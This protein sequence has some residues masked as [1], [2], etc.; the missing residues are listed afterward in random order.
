MVQHIKTIV[1]KVH[2][3]RPESEKI[4]IAAQVIRDGGLVAF[5][6]ETVYGLGANAL[7]ERAVLKIFESKKR[8]ADNPLIVHI[9]NINDVYLLAERLPKGAEV[10]INKFWPG[11]LTLIVPRSELVPDAT[12]AGL[13]TVA[14]RMPSHP[15]ARALIAE[16]NVPIAAPSA[17]IAGMP[18]PTTVT[19]VLADLNGRIEAVIDGGEITYGV[20][21]TVL[22]ITTDPPTIL[23]PGPA[24]V[25]EL[26]DLI[27]EVRVHPVARAEV[28]AEVVIA[29]S[30]G[31]KYKH[32]APAAEIVVV[33]GNLEKIQV[34]VQELANAQR[35]S[36]KKVG[37]VA[38]EETAASYHAD[39]VKIVGSRRDPRTVSKNLF[40][41]L[42]ELDSEGV[43]SA[44][45]EGIEPLGIGLAVMN[46]LR[47]AAGHNIVRVN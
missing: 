22:D 15:V 43:S 40:R 25:E 9:S 46:R 1:L 3:E 36:G 42:R 24:T 47:K 2:P 8:P 20:E 23:R 11:P 14:I 38:T 5:P 28:S 12:T 30:P 34:K 32:Y 6:T 10:L 4:R 27:G 39:V 17:N 41:I 37:I 35:K 16:A 13:A 45:A 7:D 29:R 33:E 31:M 19:H 18:S 26:Q 44:V 21:S